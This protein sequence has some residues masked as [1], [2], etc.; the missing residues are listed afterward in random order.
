MA[1]LGIRSRLGLSRGKRRRTSER[2][3]RG[4]LGSSAVI[5]LQSINTLQEPNGY[6]TV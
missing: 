5:Q 3:H 1:S 2:A 4:A 6:G